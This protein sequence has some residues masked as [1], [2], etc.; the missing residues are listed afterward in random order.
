MALLTVAL[1]AGQV[2]VLALISA[3]RVARKR[4]RGSWCRPRLAVALVLT[5]YEKHK[6]VTEVTV[7]T[8]ERRTVAD[9]AAEQGTVG[10]VANKVSL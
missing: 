6:R 5:T 10:R 7:K 3:V 9:A 2:G 1:E 8:V 4:E